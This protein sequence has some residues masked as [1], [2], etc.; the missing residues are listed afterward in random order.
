MTYSELKYFLDNKMRMSHI[1]QPVMILKLLENGTSYRQEI[2]ETILS[3]D[4]SQ[5]DYYEDITNNMVGKVLI[6]HNIVEKEN[7]QTWKFESSSSNKT[8]T[9]RYNASG[10]LSC[11]CMG[12]IGHGRCRHIK[13]V[14][15]LVGEL[16]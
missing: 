6:G 10:K 12:Y 2:A 13:E 1:Y 3:Y 9:V 7:K 16:K 14:E 15:G 5:K 11:D 4:E 8:Y